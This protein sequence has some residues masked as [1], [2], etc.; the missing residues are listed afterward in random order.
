MANIDRPVT[1]IS[2]AYGLRRSMK[3]LVDVALL[4]EV[5]AGE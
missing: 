3:L 1:P 5:D 2:S 4:V